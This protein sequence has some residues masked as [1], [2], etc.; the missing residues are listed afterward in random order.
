MSSGLIFITGA[1]GF[2]G[3]AVALEAL[4]AGYRLRISVRKESQVPQLK[5]L[6][7]QY[8]DKIEFVVVPEITQESSF[9]GKLDGVDYVLHLASPLPHGVDKET[10]FG[11]AVD[12]TTAVLKEAAKVKSIKRVVITS[13]IAALIPITGAPDGGVIRENNGW[14][15]SVDASADFT[16]P[17]PAATAFKLYHASK[18][19]ANNASWDFKKTENPH[20]SLVTLHPAFVYGHNHTQ[21]RAEDIGGTNGMLFGTIMTGTPSG[22]ITA[23]HVQDVAEAQIKALN[24]AVPDGSR[25]LLAGPKASWSDVARIVKRDYPSLGAKIAEGIPGASYALDTSEAEKVLG[26]KWRSLDQMVKDVVEQQVG[27]RKANI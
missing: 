15:L 9:A 4:K 20:F 25:F 7:A 2:I 6:F 1:T 17:S 10:Y 27:L 16:G 19:L 21:T 11:P 26:M 18:L 8:E 23:V 24:D 13:S 14:D 3:S 22:N 12:G 5:K